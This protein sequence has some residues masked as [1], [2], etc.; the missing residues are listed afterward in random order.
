MN[1]GFDASTRSYPIRLGEIVDIYIHNVAGT[2]GLL[3]AH[4]WHFHGEH[5]YHIATGLLVNSTNGTL[6]MSSAEYSPAAPTRRDTVV[7]FPGVG[8]TYLNHTEK[9]ANQTIGG[10]VQLRLNA[11]V[12]GAWIVH[13]HLTVGLFCPE[14]Q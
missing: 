10:Y 9:L 7:T 14:S 1:D 3:E 5:P 2:S 8:A 12:P 6:R 4:P 13:C 11:T